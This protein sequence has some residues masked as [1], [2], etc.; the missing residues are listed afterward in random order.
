MYRFAG[1]IIV[2]TGAASGICRA[3][4]A[5]LLAEGAQLIAVDRD[6]TASQH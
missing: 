2:V 6:A 1:K 3:T 5:R 4:V